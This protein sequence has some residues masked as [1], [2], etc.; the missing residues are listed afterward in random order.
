MSN[1]TILMDDETGLLTVFEYGK[2]RF[3]LEEEYHTYTIKDRG[4]TVMSTTHYVEALRMMIKFYETLSVNRALG[5][6]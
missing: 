1:I 5:I 4:I 3:Y 2:P 6:S